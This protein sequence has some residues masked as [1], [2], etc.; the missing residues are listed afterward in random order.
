MLGTLRRLATIAAVATAALLAAALPA[1][2]HV[3]VN[4]DQAEQGGY[5]ELTFRVP[6][7]RDDAATTKLEVAFPQDHPLTSVSVK[8]HPGWT[9]EVA[10][11]KLDEP[12]N[13]GSSEVT[14]VV[15]RIT[16]TAND[17]ESAVK[18]GEYDAFSVSAG[19]MPNV[20]QIVFKALQTY[21]GGEVVRWIE[22]PTGGSEPEH[23][24]LVL[25]LVPAGDGGDT[26]EAAPKAP[27]AVT[28]S[29]SGSSGSSPWTLPLSV[30]ALLI[31][32]GA[33]ALAGLAWRRSHG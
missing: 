3:T 10:T 18:P 19:R 2:A 26:P 4:P 30:A 23:P 25:K 24:A 31:A 5:E 13:T 16:W 1:A 20:D 9:Y 7:E 33:A 8:P 28:T 32:V 12:I 15:D 11:R 6:N 29:S 22:M 17:D 21:E 27:A 14:K